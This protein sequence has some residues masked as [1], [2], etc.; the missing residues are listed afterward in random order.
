[1]FLH[2]DEPGKLVITLEKKPLL[3]TPMLIPLHVVSSAGLRMHHSR[4]I[5]GCLLSGSN[6]FQLFEKNFVVLENAHLSCSRLLFTMY[7]GSAG[8]LGVVGGAT[9]NRTTDFLRYR[10][11]YAK[12][13]APGDVQ[14]RALSQPQ[15][16][17]LIQDLANPDQNGSVE[18]TLP[19]EWMVRVE[20]VQNDLATLKH[21]IGDLKRLHNNHLLVEIGDDSI[22]DVHAI[23][24]ST[25]EI[26]LLFGETQRKIKALNKLP[27]TADATTLSSNYIKMTL[28][29]Q[30]ALATQLQE[31]TQLF[32]TAQQ[33]YLTK[34][35]SRDSK[36]RDTY[37]SSPSMS[38]ASASSSPSSAALSA[39]STESSFNI[40]DFEDK[41][42]TP[43]QLAVLEAT[44]RDAQQRYR[45]IKQIAKSIVELSEIVKDISLLIAEQGTIL[46]RID[47]N[48]DKTYEAVEIARQEIEKAAVLQSKTRYKICF[49]ML[50]VGIL[51]AGLALFV[52]LFT[53]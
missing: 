12:K 18:L 17:K 6:H 11:N 52:R 42:F 1:M 31:L 37:T 9:R 21:K 24:I 4:V 20:S 36:F 39:T 44:D 33:H 53:R 51:C 14:M 5:G 49:I 26:S 15:T 48:I 32:K 23:E 46:D 38:S 2:K 22:D 19:P 7:V 13:R 35:R 40:E 34:L 47:Y 16:T 25:A 50:I 27:P 29:I 43:E 8:V 45:D 28:N 10:E 41:G 3:Q 30:T